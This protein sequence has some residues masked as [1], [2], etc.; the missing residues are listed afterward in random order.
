MSIPVGEESCGWKEVKEVQ[1]VTPNSLLPLLLFC[2]IFESI[3][4]LLAM[5]TRTAT[6]T[7]PVRA[8][9]YSPRQRFLAL[10]LITAFLGTSVSVFQTSA[11]TTAFRSRLPAHT[12][13]RLTARESAFPVPSLPYFADK[14]SFD[15]FPS[16]SSLFTKKLTPERLLIA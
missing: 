14:V 5:S 13:S 12:L 10:L 15:L 11:A 6:R 1:D 9:G 2:Y 16:S 4:A 3:A 8:T 7:T